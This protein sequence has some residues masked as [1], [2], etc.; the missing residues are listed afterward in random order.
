MDKELTQLVERLKRIFPHV[1]IQF[2]GVIF[3]ESDFSE[4]YAP[5]REL[6]WFELIERLKED[7][8]EISN[9][10]T[11]KRTHC[12]CG[13]PINFSDIDC[14]TFNLCKNCAQDS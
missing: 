4:D 3:N 9:I 13:K 6:D 5:P 11:K 2:E 12:H 14:A 10:K 1:T 8:L 7:G